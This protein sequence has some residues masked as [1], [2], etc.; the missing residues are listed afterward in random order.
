MVSLICNENEQM[1]VNAGNHNNFLTCKLTR[2]VS[3]SIQ[4]ARALIGLDNLTPHQTD[5]PLRQHPFSSQEAIDV[6]RTTSYMQVDGQTQ[7]TVHSFN[8]TCLRPSLSQHLYSTAV[9]N[10]SNYTLIAHLALKHAL[11]R[12]PDTQSSILKLIHQHPTLLF[13]IPILDTI[14]LRGYGSAFASLF[15]SILPSFYSPHTFILPLIQSSH[16]KNSK[17][18]LLRA[19]SYLLHLDYIEI[20]TDQAEGLIP[21][22][23]I[24]YA[25]SAMSAVINIRNIGVDTIVPP[26]PSRHHGIVN[27]IYF[28]TASCIETPKHVLATDVINLPL[29]SPTPRTRMYMYELLIR[30][31]FNVKG[32]TPI[33]SSLKNDLSCQQLSALMVCSYVSLTGY[34]NAPTQSVSLLAQAALVK[35]INY[36]K[37]E[38]DFYLSCLQNQ[39]QDPLLTCHCTVLCNL[40]QHN[41]V[42]S[43]IPN[44]SWKDIG[45]AGTIRKELM[46][47]IKPKTG[48]TTTEALG[49][50]FSLQRRGVLLYGPP[51]SGKT[52]VAKALAGESGIGF[53][54]A[55][56]GEILS[57]YIGESEKK[58][59][60]L[61]IN[62]RN[63][64]PCVLF[65]DE[66]DSLAPSKNNAGN[67]GGGGVM[68]RIVSQLLLEIDALND[69]GIDVFLVGATNRPELLD[70][71]LLRPGRLD[72]SIY[73]G[74]SETVDDQLQILKALSRKFTLGPKVN[75]RRIIEAYCINRPL[76]GADFF[77][78][79]ST[80]MTLAIM[81]A[82]NNVE[83]EKRGEIIDLDADDYDVENER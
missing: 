76:T 26:L 21:E 75:L 11:L 30:M 65:L 64:A 8:L 61:F 68:Q 74:I 19:L 7:F 28:L 16:T 36:F 35:S 4:D 15:D 56:A 3:P 2:S 62:A 50:A 9:T 53:V 23:D 42:A 34:T 47:L 13:N 71:S 10:Q 60:E 43:G 14:L 1:A 77:A 73:V 39:A 57:M 29:P 72:R 24:Q 83:R 66:I 41:N 55:N 32:S 5:T 81:D 46:Q 82:V 58:I 79:A 80:S 54:T 37:T 67:S 52:L 17:A 44:V 38:K 63:S 6:H 18:T 70:L 12:S 59:R 25:S 22:G 45:A 48:S 49:N 78:L 27:N 20:D 40:L 31:T 33:L 51:G 69:D